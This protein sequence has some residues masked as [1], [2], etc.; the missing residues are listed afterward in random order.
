M[1]IY[2]IRN[3]VWHFLEIQKLILGSFKRVSGL[4]AAAVVVVVER[5]FLLVRVVCYCHEIQQCSRNCC[6][7]GYSKMV[8]PNFE[9]TL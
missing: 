7:M 9:R 4:F 5:L 3:F 1:D 8:S 6:K 2:L